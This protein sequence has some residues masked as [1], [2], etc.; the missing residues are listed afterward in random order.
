MITKI[1]IKKKD[2]ADSN[3]GTWKDSKLKIK[4]KGDKHLIE[5]I[6][7]VIPKTIEGY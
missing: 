4:I 7:K 5:N 3:P 1:K 2:F 6:I